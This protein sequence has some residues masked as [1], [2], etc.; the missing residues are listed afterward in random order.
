M[1]AS[2]IH[3][4]VQYNICGI[5]IRRYARNHCLRQVD[6]VETI[7]GFHLQDLERLGSVPRVGGFPVFYRTGTTRS[8]S[9]CGNVFQGRGAYVR[10]RFT[11]DLIWP[12]VYTFFLSTAISWVYARALTADSL[13][14]GAN[15]GPVLAMLFDYLE[16]LSAS[17]VMVRYPHPTIVVDSLASLF[18]MSK[19]VLMIGSVGLL[20][21]GTAIVIW[22]WIMKRS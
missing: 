7:I 3:N 11:F 13:W 14:R 1:V 2:S 10:A 18:T 4:R 22:Q 17:L 9:Q 6:N 19:W 16:N 5:G 21:G 8:G 12:L 20:F 15:L